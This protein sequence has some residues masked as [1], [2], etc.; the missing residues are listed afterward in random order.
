MRQLIWVTLFLG[1]L[2]PVLA[3]EE[4]VITYGNDL[5]PEGKDVR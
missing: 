1:L 5:T 4:R 3:V 2:S